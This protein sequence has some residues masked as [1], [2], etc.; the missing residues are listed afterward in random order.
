M[1]VQA[2]VA[3]GLRRVAG[4]PWAPPGGRFEILGFDACLMA[5]YDVMASLT[6]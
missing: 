6:P 2:E 1:S 5:Q 4:L 3:E